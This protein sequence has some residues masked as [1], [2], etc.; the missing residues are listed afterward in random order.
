MNEALKRPENLLSEA[1]GRLKSQAPGMSMRGV[2]GRLQI[3][4]SYWSKIL[5]GKK[6]LPISLLPRVV[7]VLNLDTQQVAQLQRSILET[8]EQERLIPVTGLRTSREAKTSP[9]EEYRSLGRDEFWIL[10]EWYY[11]PLLNLFTVTEFHPT[12]EGLAYRL[13]L[14]SQQVSEAILRLKHH[15]YLLETAGG[16]VRTEQKVR[17]PTNR[18]HAQVRHYHNSMLQKAREELLQFGNDERFAGRLIS[19]VSFAGSSEKLKE[20]RLILEEAMY[21]AANLMANEPKSDEIYQLNVQLFPL[22]KRLCP[23]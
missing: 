14:N 1:A 22:S 19:A 21:R 5:R 2:A 3:T 11:I 7:K 4:P 16:L 10:E 12:V 13:G 18:S 23:K 15:G 9:I 17:F 6:P 20:A 8:I